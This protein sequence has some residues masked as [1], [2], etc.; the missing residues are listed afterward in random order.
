MDNVIYNDRLC[1]ETEAENETE[2]EFNDA[3]SVMVLKVCL[4]GEC[5]NTKLRLLFRCIC[6]S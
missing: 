2:E 5:F 3:T 6:T 4:T 1:I